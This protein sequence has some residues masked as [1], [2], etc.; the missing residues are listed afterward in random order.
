MEEGK[1]LFNSGLAKLERIHKIR[2]SMYNF[3]VMDDYNNYADS[4]MSWRDEL[5]YGDMNKEE[6]EQCDKAERMI[7][8]LLNR[9]DLSNPQLKICLKEYTRLINR[10][11]ARLGLG[12]PKQINSSEI[13]RIT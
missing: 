2:M 6:I 12:M 4:L 13:A 7:E 8:G 9:N 11:E 10:I 3:R 1:A 5:D